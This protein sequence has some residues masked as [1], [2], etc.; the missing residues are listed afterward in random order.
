MTPFSISEIDWFHRDDS[1]RYTREYELTRRAIEDSDKHILSGMENTIVSR[2]RILCSDK[3][4]E[5]DESSI[6]EA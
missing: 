3:P 5:L 1:L 2:D 6:D 4:I